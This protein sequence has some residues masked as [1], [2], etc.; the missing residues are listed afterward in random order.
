[1]IGRGSP[2][3]IIADSLVCKVQHSMQSE[4]RIA[5]AVSK[6]LSPVERTVRGMEYPGTGAR[7]AL[8]E[9]SRATITTNTARIMV[10]DVSG[11]EKL[12]KDEI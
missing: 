12:I 3:L 1:M 11:S 9:A 4:K 2:L 6:T 8:A 7:K 10:Y 5:A